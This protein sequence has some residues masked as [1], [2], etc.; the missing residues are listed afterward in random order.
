MDRLRNYFERWIKFGEIEK[1]FDKVLD[2]MLRE[3]FVLNCNKP[4]AVFLKE[5]IPQKTSK[6]NGM[7]G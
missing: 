3:Q 4:L 2:L 6:R 1:S 7:F 5:R